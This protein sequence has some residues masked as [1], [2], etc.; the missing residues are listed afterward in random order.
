MLTV[1]EALE[2]ILE[3]EDNTEEA[4]D[5]IFNPPRDGNCSDEEEGDEETVNPGNL[6]SNQLNA[7]AEIVTDSQADIPDNDDDD[8]QVSRGRNQI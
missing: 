5:V 4:G 6:T 1:S 3:E 8:S 2:I 7:P